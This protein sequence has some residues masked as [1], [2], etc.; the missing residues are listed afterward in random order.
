MCK[1]LVVCM[2]E[3]ASTEVAVR[4]RSYSASSG[5][6]SDVGRDI[7]RMRSAVIEASLHYTNTITGLMMW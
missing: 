1:S 7:R 6:G 5:S 2:S 4:Q 3:Q